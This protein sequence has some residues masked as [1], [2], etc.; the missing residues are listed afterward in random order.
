MGNVLI[1]AVPTLLGAVVGGLATFFSS[2]RAFSRQERAEAKKRQAELVRD[3][4][5]RFLSAVSEMDNKRIER[6][7][8]TGVAAAERTEALRKL[9]PEVLQAVANK[10]DIAPVIEKARALMAGNDAPHAN[11]VLMRSVGE[12]M[13]GVFGTRVL[14]DEM[15]LVLP[16]KLLK[17][18]DAAF[19]AAMGGSVLTELAA[20]LKGKVDQKSLDAVD[21]SGLTSKR[22][23]AINEYV[24]AVRES[25]DLDVLDD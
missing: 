1:N 19:L 15:R 16:R 6:M 12:V 5:I 11:A 25:Y 17:K 10:Q 23:A 9:L 18:A 4:S 24:N 3:I 2:S 7:T 21:S 14:Y 8:N 22:D 13:S 20:L